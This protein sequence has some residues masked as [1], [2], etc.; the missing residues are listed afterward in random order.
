MSNIKE[1]PLERILRLSHFE[2]AHRTEFYSVLLDSTIYVLGR[3]LDAKNNTEG[4]ANVALG[5][6]VSIRSWERRDGSSMI[7]FFSSLEVLQKSAGSDEPYLAVPAKSLFEM[8]KGQTL[9]LNPKSDYK[10]EFDADE[11]QQL[12]SINLSREVNQRVIQKQAKVVLGQPAKYPTAMVDQ[13]TQLLARH[14]AVNKGYF[15]LM[16]DKSAGAKPRLVVGFLVDEVDPQQPFELL[17]KQ[18]SEVIAQSAPQGQ[19]VDLY[20]VIENKP[21]LS[22][23]FIQKTQAFYDRSWGSKLCVSL[24]HGK[25]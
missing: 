7:P 5:D 18:A 13:L 12:L 17:S 6:K 16:H 23:F 1:N 11:V 10:K 4:C 25:A 20:R 14:S 21:G 9:A 3:M 2:P 24:G 22:Q 15:L 19:P 8:T